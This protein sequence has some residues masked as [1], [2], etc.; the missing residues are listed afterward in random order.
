MK[1][2]IQSLRV[3]GFALLVAIA[4]AVTTSLV[5][6]QEP[7]LPVR[8]L[9]GTQFWG[10]ELVLRDWRIQ[11]NVVTGHYRLLDERNVRRAW[12]TREA[13]MTKFDEIRR[14][15]AIEPH[16]GNVVVLVHGLGRS[17]HFMDSMASELRGAGY[18]TVNFSYPSTRADIASHAEGLSHVI[19]HLNEAK[20]IHFVAHSL[21]NLVVRHCLHRETEAAKAAGKPFDVR[22]KR[23]VMLGPPNHG[24]AMARLFEEVPLYDVVLR[25][26][27]KDLADFTA[28]AEKLGSP[29][30][31]FGIVA[32]GCGDD[33]GWNPLL[34]GDDDLLVRVD[35]TRLAGA[36]DFRLVN[37]RHAKLGS[38]ATVMEM[39]R[40]FLQNG[41]FT[42]AAQR[43]PIER[44]E[45]AP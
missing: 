30:C 45:A 40:C 28:L 8:T 29:P 16:R 7:N 6:A 15:Q 42:T 1:Q 2:T 14:A 41:A 43:Q 17:R 23:F 9:G 35:E 36:H 39:S 19:G 38:D 44:K 3:F 13:C 37:V 25:G 31:E 27:G 5:M 34:D 18:E 21:G 12:G 11:R 24:A 22:I 20:E 33:A 10:D 26:V 4:Y 32:G